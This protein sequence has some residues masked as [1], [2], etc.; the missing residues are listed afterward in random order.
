MTF[1]GRS[2]VVTLGAGVALTVAC[3]DMVAPRRPATDP[4]AIFDQVWGEFDRHYSLFEAK[5]VDWH[6]LGEHYR[7]LALGSESELLGALCRML[8]TLKDLHVTLYTPGTVCGRIARRTDAY[9]P[10][11]ATGPFYLAGS[12]N[13]F[14][15]LLLT[16]GVIVSY[17]AGTADV[18]YLRISGFTDAR[19]PSEVDSAL[20]SLHFVSAMIIDLRLNAGGSS[21]LAEQIAGRFVEDNRV[22]ALGRFRNGPSHSDFGD[23]IAYRVGP[24]GARHFSGSVA[25]VVNRK[26]GSASEDFVMAM[27]TRPRVI[28]V[29]DTTS[30]TATDPLWRDLPNGWAF[31]LSQSI[32]STPGGFAPSVV[33]GIPPM[34]FARTSQSDSARQI[35]A[36]LDAA[37]AALRR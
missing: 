9:D 23:P 34:I 28:I 31:R 3:F 29:G 21:V 30:G 19:L 13:S 18:G 14:P 5:N 24:T 37:L 6:A 15:S 7:P 2:L 20:A 17:P 22:Y 16:S 1:R 36:S 27:L 25:L 11:I 33:G 12:V 32:E 4:G 35:D 26:V 10:G 8:D